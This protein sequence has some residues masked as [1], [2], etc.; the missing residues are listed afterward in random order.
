MDVKN[1]HRRLHLAVHQHVIIVPMFSDFFGGIAQPPRDHRLGILGSRTQPFFENLPARRKNKYRNGRREFSLFNCRAP[2]TS[3]SSTRST[4]SAAA[5]SSSLDMG[6]VIVAENLGM[7]Q[8]FVV[9]DA[10]LELLRE[11]K[12]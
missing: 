10:R 6:P 9:R 3:M 8:K 2:W 4:P 7:F 5:R 1:I 11:M 12:K